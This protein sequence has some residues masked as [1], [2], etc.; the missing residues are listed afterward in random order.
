MTS[1]ARTRRP[2]ESAAFARS[3]VTGPRPLSTV[4]RLLARSTRVTRPLRLP[5]ARLADAGL[6]R[7][8]RAPEERDRVGAHVADAAADAAHLHAVRRAEIREAGAA[9]EDLRRAVDRAAET[10]PARRERIGVDEDRA[11]FV[12]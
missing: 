2:V 11:V 8:D 4:T 7:F 6:R 10:V 9:D 3:T 12:V 1:V 5:I